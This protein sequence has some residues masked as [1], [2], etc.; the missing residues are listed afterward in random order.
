MLSDGAGFSDAH[1]GVIR[2]NHY[3]REKSLY[4]S[5]QPNILTFSFNYAVPFQHKYLG[6]WSLSGV[7]AYS[8]SFPM[9]ISTNNINSFLFTG[10]L[11][12]NLT[13]QDIRATIAGGNFDPNRDAYLNRAAFSQPATM[14]FGNAPVYLNL[15]P[16]AYMQ[17]SFGL[18]KD[19]RLFEGGNLQLRMEISNPFNR[20][21]FGTPSTDFSAPNFGRI[22]GVGNSPRVIQ[23]GLKMSF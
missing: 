22:G 14:T 15:R 11:R 3:Q 7:G 17:E 19:T 18:F 5:D 21:R 12:P 20:V 1:G 13:G 8:D 4:A 16:P 23:F 6:G 9:A 10:G 2:Q